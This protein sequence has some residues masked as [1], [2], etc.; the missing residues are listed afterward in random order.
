[1][2]FAA[3]FAL[4]ALRTLVLVPRLPSSSG[5]TIAVA[6]ELPIILTLSWLASRWLVGRFNVVQ[7]LGARLLMGATAFV[8]LLIGEF[9]LGYLGFGRSPIEQFRSYARLPDFVGLMGQLT[10]AAFPC[11][12]LLLRPNSEKGTRP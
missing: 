4:G 11:G 12:Q 3:G 6:I 9:L 10:F 2:I 5:E 7:A 8:L 1:V